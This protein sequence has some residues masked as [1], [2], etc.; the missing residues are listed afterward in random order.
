MIRLE[1][2][3]NITRISVYKE[4]KVDSY[5]WHD[6]KEIK[7]FK[8]ITHPWYKFKKET[9]E[10]LKPITLKAGFYSSNKIE[11]EYCLSYFGRYKPDPENH[12]E[13]KDFSGEEYIIKDGR[14]YIKP[15][16]HFSVAGRE[17][18]LYEYFDTFEQAVEY[19]KTF[20]KFGLT[21]I[22]GG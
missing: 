9:K 8:M 16:V 5:F 3:E 12:F 20:M 4:E 7:V 13:P 10:Y 17:P 1:R 22:I 18:D 21:A 11:D 14:V 15:Y 19:A 2:P 6:A